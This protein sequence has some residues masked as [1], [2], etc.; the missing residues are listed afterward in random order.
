MPLHA[1]GADPRCRAIEQI[2]NRAVARP[3][4]RIAA[5]RSIAQ[6]SATEPSS[7]CDGV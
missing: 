6:K 1:A 2:E 7:W 3:L 5:Y 4:S